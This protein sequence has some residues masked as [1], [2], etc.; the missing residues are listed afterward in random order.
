MTMDKYK[1]M[2]D[3]EYVKSSKRP[4][5]SMYDRA[6]Q[7]SP[8]A[9]LTG[10]DEAIKETARLTEVEIELDED[11]K[12]KLNEKIVLLSKNLDIASDVSVTYF[13]RD[14]LK[15]GGEYVT[16]KGVVIKIDEYRQV[17]IMEVNDKR[18][19]IQISSIIKIDCV[20]FNGNI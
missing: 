9:A 4:H 11:S 2:L 18:L 19:N 13:V 3:I 10:H 20:I 7:F 5:M 17:I 1:D 6:A 14:E 8:F 15:S 16:V 12:E